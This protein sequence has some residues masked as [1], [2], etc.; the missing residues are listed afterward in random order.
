[1][2]NDIQSEVIANL[3]ETAEAKL[4]RH[5]E[6]EAPRLH[7]KL[8]V[9]SGHVHNYERFKH[10][11]ISYI[12]SGGGGTKPYPV[13]V[14]NPEDLYHATGYPNFNVLVFAVHGKQA[15]GTTYRLADPNAKA[16]SVEVKERFTLTAK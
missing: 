4:W 7:A 5:L 16:M 6:G 10:G 8:I 2:I 14:R 15:D 9:V 12:V 3:P 1:M 11:G 13:Y